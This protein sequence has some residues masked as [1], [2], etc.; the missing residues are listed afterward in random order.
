[1]H[2]RFEE[3]LAR[4]LFAIPLPQRLYP[5]TMEIHLLPQE[6]AAMPSIKLSLPGHS[7]LPPVDDEA[8]TTLL[9]KLSV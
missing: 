1:M 5:V 7:E 6:H 2:A 4:L 8:I 9:E 3:Y